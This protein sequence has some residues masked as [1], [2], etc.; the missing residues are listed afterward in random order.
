MN[1]RD[2]LSTIHA[3]C[4]EDAPRHVYA[5]WL[6]MTGQRA[7]ADVVRAEIETAGDGSDAAWERLHRARG[8]VDRGWLFRWE[9]PSLMRSLPLPI[10]ADPSRLPISLQ[11]PGDHRQRSAFFSRPD[12]SEEIR[13]LKWIEGLPQREEVH[14][15]RERPDYW[16]FA[17]F[18]ASQGLPMPGEMDTLVRSYSDRLDTITSR[19]GFFILGRH[20]PIP[21][22]GGA[23]LPCHQD[24]GEQRFWGLW[25]H[26]SGAHAVVSFALFYCERMEDPA[27]ENNL[28]AEWAVRDVRFAGTSLTEFLYRRA[29][30]AQIRRA[31]RGEGRLRGA[32]TPEE[33]R[34]LD[35]YRRPL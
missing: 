21:H 20:E 9:Q 33:R 30:E 4:Q 25:L 22:L 8:A 27:E 13:S 35:G 11:P 17:R 1:E 19:S 14:H 5:D 24:T 12:L 3:A 26:R 18:V 10:R 28:D 23:I 31:F 7:E 16:R 32:Y 29:M 34:Y 6:E 15:R 2:L